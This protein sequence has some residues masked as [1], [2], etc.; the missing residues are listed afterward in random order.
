MSPRSSSTTRSERIKKLLLSKRSWYK[1]AVK[2]IWII[3]VCF[4]LGLP[5]YI[6]CVK[7]N[8]F[9][10]FG[11]MPSLRDIENPEND[12]SSELISADGISLGRYFRF[13]RSQVSY[14]QLSPDLINTLLIS[15]DHR[16]HE[17]SG[18]DFYAFVRVIYGVVTFDVSSKGGGSTISQQ[19]AKN[20]FTINPELD[21][22]IANLGALPKRVVQKTKEWIIAVELEKN[23]TKQE[24]IAMYF[25]T[26]DFGSN[27]FGIKIAAET[28]FKKRPANLNIQESAILVGLLQ[29]PSFFSPRYH[30]ER[31]LIKRNEV[32]SKLREHGYLKS[33]LQYDS[34]T[35]LPIQLK[36]SVQNQNAGIAPY[37]LNAIEGDLEK[38][39]KEHG[40]SLLESGLK[41][42]T[43]IDSRFQ[44]H[45]N[46]AVAE[47]MK[48]QQSI[49]NEHW[50]GR[51]PW[52]D[53]DGNEIEGFLESRMK[54][55]DNYRKL[56]AK[57]GPESDSV[58]IKLN[59]K[60][61]M[62]IF[63][64]N[65]ERDTTFSLVD[66]LN[67]YKR[68]LQSSF[69]AMDPQTGEVKA[70]VGGIGYKFFK[71]DQ[72]RQ[73]KRQP[74]STFKPIVYGAAMEAG[75]KPCQKMQDIS[76]TI[77]LANGKT[78]I[79]PN[80]GG[81]FGTGEMLTL[82][83]ALA[84]SK[85]SI[86]A[87]L[88][89]LTGIENVI[90]FARRLGITSHLDA[91]PTLSLGVSDVSLYELVGAYSTFV[92]LGTYTEPFF[93]TRIE[94]RNG[95]VIQN[96][97]PKTKQSISEQTA[98]TMVYMLMGGVDE[99]GGSSRALSEEVREG[100]EVGGKT[101]TTNNASDGWYIGITHNLVGGAWVGGVER[102]IRYRQWSMGSGG[103]TA[104][105]IWDSF[106]Q[107]VY[108]DM[109]LEYEKGDFRRPDHLDISLDC[110]KYDDPN[111][112]GQKYDPNEEATH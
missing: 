100:N 48:T 49:F 63:T 67:Y 71:Y 79:P 40:F 58:K 105:P 12:L 86:S 42:Y 83:Q 95:N 99:E 29:N 4:L 50:R 28:F 98:F 55:T 18:L 15:E 69:M 2:T 1:K 81:D 106:L 62:R 64:W 75:F 51:N 107:K 13:N 47:S 77:T 85:N 57:Y 94:D 7:V 108:A 78:W 14:D 70:W 35:A 38:W 68:F 73:G 25:N 30:P 91:V 19:L 10:L 44:R 26:C 32:L 80:S 37:F 17:H 56:V 23:F 46:A 8:L 33:K 102:S 92:N 74:G 84:R 59:E 16:F 112:D 45:A 27:A 66:S 103:R 72:V 54:L 6:L 9:G 89:Q 41:I 5:T 52:I 3:F 21:G 39:C 111:D 31:A 96:F 36:Y 76:P 104:L 88:M 109:N 110:S 53:E 60:K 34:L 61:R 90:S 22:S 24:I 97:V 87:K 20:L 93:I 101:G 65:G 82:R 11:E 43:T